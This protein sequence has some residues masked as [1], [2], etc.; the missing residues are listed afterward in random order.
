MAITTIKVP[1]DWA[2]VHDTNRCTYIFYSSKFTM[3]NFQFYITLRFFPADDT[4]VIDIGPFLFYPNSGGTCQFNP[5]SIIKDYLTY[6]FD[7]A[8][9]NLHECT[10]SAAKVYMMVYEYYSSTATS[11]PAI[12][13]APINAGGI[14]YYIGC[15]QFLPYDNVTIGYSNTQWVMVNSATTG[16][17]LTDATQYNLDNT[18]YGFI[19]FLSDSAHRPSQILYTT[20]SNSTGIPDHDEDRVIGI[21]INARD[22]VLS[23]SMPLS[24]NFIS[25]DDQSRNYTPLCTQM[26]Y[27]FEDCT[28][29]YTGSLM[30]SIP[31]GPMQMLQKEYIDNTWVMI[32]I[33]L[34]DNH[35]R[36]ISKPFW[37]MRKNKCSRY[38][39]T[40]VFWLNP[41]GAFDCYTFDRKATINEKIDRKTYKQYLPPYYNTYTAGEKVFYTN[42]TEELILT[43]NWVTQQESQLLI[44]MAQSPVVY[45]I[46]TYQYDPSGY[47]IY[48]YAVPYIVNTDSIKYEQKVNDKEIQYTISLRPA[49]DK[50]IQQN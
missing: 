9:L 32:K 14:S 27:N 19:N 21:N 15:Q 16:K 17:W 45:V 20:Y 47:G 48:P 29:T 25:L 33:E 1:S 3:T 24:S 6:D 44:Q 40:Q 18:D 22:E 50:V 8:R 11:Q 37:V 49:N 23:Q 36:V 39:L 34:M 2:R 30:Y 10:P 38:N 46:K 42:V 4:T 43:S 26:S 31:C 41:H 35:S 12:Q 5:T 7:V 13:G 28:Y